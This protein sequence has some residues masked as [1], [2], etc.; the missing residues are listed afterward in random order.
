VP[1]EVL[2]RDVVKRR[3]HVRYRRDGV[4]GL[5]GHEDERDS[6]GAYEVL[7]AAEA[8]RVDAGELCPR[9]FPV[10]EGVSA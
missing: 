7:T 10:P 9:C 6:S 1:T 4:R 5:W 3:V 8:E 2:V